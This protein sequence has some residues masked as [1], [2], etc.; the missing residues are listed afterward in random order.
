MM[1]ERRDVLQSNI[2]ILHTAGEAA[3]LR[4]NI[5]KTKTL[6]FGSEPIEEQMKVGN[7]DLENVIEFEYLG[8][9]LSW[10]NMTVPWKGD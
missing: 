4:I 2:N 7:K 8:S 5:G 1:E 3:G 6:V 10:D 9:L